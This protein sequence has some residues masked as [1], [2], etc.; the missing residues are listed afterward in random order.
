MKAAALATN[1]SSFFLSGSSGCGVCECLL[2]AV[3]S[4]PYCMD[5]GPALQDEAV[6][7]P[8]KSIARA[9]LEMAAK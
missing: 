2:D 7:E 6:R 8:K 9:T 5:G 3:Q 4:L 1:S